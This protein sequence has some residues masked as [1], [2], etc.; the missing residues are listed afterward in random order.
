MQ[1]W[2]VLQ[3][4]VAKRGFFFVTRSSDGMKDISIEWIGCVCSILGFWDL[5]QGWEIEGDWLCSL[6]IVARD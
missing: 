1:I 2:L 4:K 6:W 3:G 5:V